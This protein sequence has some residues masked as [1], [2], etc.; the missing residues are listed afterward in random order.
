VPLP[1]SEQPDSA[2]QA[3]GRSGPCPA[4]GPRWVHVTTVS[5]G[6]QRSRTVISGSE[7]PQVASLPAQAGGVMQAGES[8]CGPDG[9][10]TR[11]HN[12]KVG[13]NPVAQCGRQDQLQQPNVDRRSQVAARRTV[14]INVGESYV[15]GCLRGR[16]RPR[17]QPPR[18]GCQRTDTESRTDLDQ[19]LH[20][21]CLPI[22]GRTR[23]A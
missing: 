3:R 22:T 14:E 8:D 7:D 15:D 12:G 10:A 17:T 21:A 4:L 13:R 5:H 19:F 6:R 11:V 20:S 1:N 9:H 18:E 2:S 16:V 23:V